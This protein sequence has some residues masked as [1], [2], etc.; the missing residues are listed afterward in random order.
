MCPGCYVGGVTRRHSEVCSPRCPRVRQCKQPSHHRSCMWRILHSELQPQAEDSATVCTVF[1]RCQWLTAMYNAFVVS[2]TSTV[3]SNAT[4][5][6][7]IVACHRCRP[8]AVQTVM[9]SLHRRYSCKQ[10]IPLPPLQTR[11][12]YPATVCTVLVQHWR[13]TTMYNACM[14]SRTCAT[15]HMRSM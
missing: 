4:H 14:V 15:L 7:Y 6:L 2:H 8:S 13:Q 11:G 10:R 9:E 1:E 12:E 5:A 3:H